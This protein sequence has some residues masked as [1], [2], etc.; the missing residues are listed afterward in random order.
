MNLILAHVQKESITSHVDLATSS[1][2]AA[3]AKS[4]VLVQEQIPA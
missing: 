1:L 4:L 3:A 2:N